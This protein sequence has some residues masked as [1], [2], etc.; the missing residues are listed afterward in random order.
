[1]QRLQPFYQLPLSNSYFTPSDLL[2]QIPIA[3]NPLPPL[4]NKEDAKYKQCERVFV[5]PN[6]D[7]Y[8]NQELYHY[9]EQNMSMPV[10]NIININNVNAMGNTY[11][12][13]GNQPVIEPHYVNPIDPI[14][15][16]TI[17]KDHYIKKY[18]S[19]LN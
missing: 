13:Y 15:T 4:E 3:Q 5:S 18:S 17:D 8:Y 12:I 19:G 6:V 2:N 1:M 9:N 14:F 7:S 10:P 16:I 11:I